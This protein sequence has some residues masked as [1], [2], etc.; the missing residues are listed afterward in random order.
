MAGWQIPSTEV[1]RV[2]NSKQRGWQG[3]RFQA[4]RLAGWQIQAQRVAGWQIPSREVGRVADSSAEVGRVADS[5]N[6]SESG[7]G[8]E[9]T[10]AK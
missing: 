2:T 9:C 1:G 4:E 3:G 5:I 8:S 10:N 7:G 6:T